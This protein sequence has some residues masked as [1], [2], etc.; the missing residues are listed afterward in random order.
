MMTWKE[1]QA[2]IAER[3]QKEAAAPSQQQAEHLAH[4]A[5][6]KARHAELSQKIG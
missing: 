1:Y 5:A 3:E 6:L 2:E 4:I